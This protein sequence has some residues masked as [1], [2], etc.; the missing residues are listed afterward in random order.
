MYSTINSRLL[1]RATSS[2]A[3]EALISGASPSGPSI[4]EWPRNRE[5]TSIGT[6]RDIVPGTAALL[7]GVGPPESACV[8]GAARPWPWGQEP[9]LQPIASRVV[10]EPPSPLLLSTRDRGQKKPHRSREGGI[11]S[12]DSESLMWVRRIPLFVATPSH[13]GTAE[14]YLSYDPPKRRRRTGSS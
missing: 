6:G 14:R 9:R 3:E 10:A 7:R 4:F 11:L 2:G 12:L 5:R 8:L 13:R 1:A